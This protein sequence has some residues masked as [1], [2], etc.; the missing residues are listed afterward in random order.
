MGLIYY[1]FI[2]KHRLTEDNPFYRNRDGPL[3]DR[4]SF[5]GAAG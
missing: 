2:W 4:F 1:Y 3:P 5:R